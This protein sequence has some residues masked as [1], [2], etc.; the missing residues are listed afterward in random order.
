MLESMRVGIEVLVSGLAVGHQ[1]GS[2][3]VNW[4]IRKDSQNRVRYVR[5][6]IKK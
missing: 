3:D 2:V 1:T 5:T 6:M 4:K